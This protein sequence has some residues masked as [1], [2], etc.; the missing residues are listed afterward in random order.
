MVSHPTSLP[1]RW[2]TSCSYSVLPLQALSRYQD[3][4]SFRYALGLVRTIWFWGGRDRAD[5]VDLWTLHVTDLWALFQPGT[6]MYRHT[7]PLSWV[8]RQ[9]FTFLG[10]NP[11]FFQYSPHIPLISQSLS[12]KCSKESS[13]TENSTAGRVLRNQH[14]RPL[15]LVET[16]TPSPPNKDLPS[17]SVEAQK[18]PLDSKAGGYLGLWG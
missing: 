3:S 10:S 14:F 18:S 8:K 9:F 11:F 15:L 6:Y 12:I 17:K 4:T 1:P 13:D 5:P 16:H 2:L 7:P